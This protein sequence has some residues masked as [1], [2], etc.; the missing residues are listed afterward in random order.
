MTRCLPSLRQL[1]GVVPPAVPVV[2]AA[3]VIVFSNG[4]ASYMP[5]PSFVP[6]GRSDEFKF[7]ESHLLD[8]PI[9]A[10]TAVALA[11]RN[12]AELAMLREAVKVARAQRKAATLIPDPELRIGYGTETS[13]GT[14]TESQP[15]I[16]ASWLSS[17]PYRPGF[18]P[19]HPVTGLTDVDWT[20]SG[21]SG[22]WQ[23]TGSDPQWRTTDPLTRWYADTRNGS[24]LPST[25]IPSTYTGTSLTRGDGQAARVALRFSPPNPWAR[26]YRAS[27]ADAMV[28]AALADLQAAEWRLSMEV[29]RNYETVQYLKRDMAALEQLV[30]LQSK[31]QSILEIRAQQ[32][33]ATILDVMTVTRK[34][35]QATADRD[36]SS[37][38][39]SN[40]MRALA[41]HLGV[42]ADSLKVSDKPTR[43]SKIGLESVGADILE[44]VALKFRTDLTARVWQSRAAAASLREATSAKVPWCSFVQATYARGTGSSSDDPSVIWAGSDGSSE[45]IPNIGSRADSDED[46]EWRIDVGIT[47]PLFS[48]LQ[49]SAVLQRAEYDR[50]KAATSALWRQIATEVRVSFSDLESS[51]QSL[52]RYEKESQPFLERMQKGLEAIEDSQDVAPDDIARIRDTIILSTRTKYKLEYEYRIAFFV[53]LEAIGK[54]VTAIEGWE[55]K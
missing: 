28:L 35:L 49:D 18:T 19:V 8:H 2:L 42:T 39:Y 30:D 38:D 25:S 37:R 10:D 45:T 40:A 3:M 20:P 48:V 32:G 54:D 29:R 31:L 9:D 34:Y 21:V 7:V 36:R 16:N 24:I 15:G 13:E 43:I 26:K 33:A 23:G 53:L 47:L 22:V 46:T 4:C 11:V 51:A 17:I 55:S 52:R 44:R 6:S 14:R 1:F 5:P 50:S 12:D 27:A 41:I